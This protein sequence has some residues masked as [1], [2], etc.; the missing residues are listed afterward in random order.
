M[1][2]RIVQRSK[3]LHYQRQVVPYSDRE[4]GAFPEIIHPSYQIR[5]AFYSRQHTLY[6]WA[7]NIYFHTKNIEWDGPNAEGGQDHR[8]KVATDLLKAQRFA[9]KFQEENV[10]PQ[11]MMS[12]KH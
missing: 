7:A 6:G 10:R 2:L 4:Y 9:D 8:I 3:Q 1:G 12:H 5:T 11:D